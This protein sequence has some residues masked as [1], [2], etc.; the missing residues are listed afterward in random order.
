MSTQR[1]Q[2]KYTVTKH[3]LERARIRF[4]V[5][6]DE[7]EAWANDI[8]RTARYVSSQGGGRLLYESSDGEIQFVVSDSTHI[9]ITVHGTL[10]LDFLKPA[11]EREVRKIKRES[12]RQ[13]RTIERHI[14]DAYSDLAERMTN[15]ANA[16][17]PNTR[18]L[19]EGRI[20][21]TELGIGDLRRKL[22]RLEDETQ[23][24]IK[25]IDVISE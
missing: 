6:T 18:L 20:K 5:E 14:A 8:M 2:Y 3:A 11:L 22:E 17:N 4:G 24:K 13:L 12:T 10:R 19:I 7:V 9:I 15:Y 21:E 1:T 25:A 16:R 23:A